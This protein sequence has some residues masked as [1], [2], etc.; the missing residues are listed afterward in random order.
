MIRGLFFD[1]ITSYS[2]DVRENNKLWLEIEKRYSESGRHYHT[3]VHLDNLSRELIPFRNK[4]SNWHTIVFSIVYHDI[5]Y[6]PLKSNNEEKSAD[7]AVARLSRSSFP[8]TETERCKRIILATR[9]HQADA[10]HDVNLFTDADLSVLGSET[11]DYFNYA[12]QIR[13]EYSV[14]PDFLY[15]PGRKKVLKHFLD[16]P[17]I[18]KTGEFRDRYEK[19]A[20]LNLQSEFDSIGKSG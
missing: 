11:T 14:Y 15:W 20:R 16:M 2:S 7:F 18:F 6:N 3:L 10:D 17:S 12:A 8:P 9:A 19:K 13:K 1:T 5:V 4:F